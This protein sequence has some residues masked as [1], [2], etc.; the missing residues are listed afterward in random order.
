MSAAPT[1]D[2]NWLPDRSAPLVGRRAESV[3]LNS[4]AVVTAA[5]GAVVAIVGLFSGAPAPVEVE[6]VRGLAVQ[7]YGSGVYRYDTLFTGAGNR[8][9]DLVTL[10]VGVPLMIGCLIAVRKGSARGRLLMPGAFAWFL[11]VYSTMSVGAAYNQLFLAYV[12]LFA[13]SIFGGALAL[14]AVDTATLIAQAHALP[15]RWPGW[16]LVVSGIATPF[17][18]VSPVVAGLVAGAVPDRLDTYSTFVTTA[19]DVAII[20]PAALIA[21]VLVLKGRGLGFVMAV[22]LLVI[23]GAL[24]PVIAAQT[25]FQRGA[26]IDFAPAELVGPI[27]AFMTLSGMAVAA[28]VLIVKAVKS[29]QGSLMAADTV[30]PS[31]RTPLTGRPS[32]TP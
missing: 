1:T 28:L 12:A 29:P 10:A 11:Y 22:P 4:L 6:S 7:L 32:S 13:I 9:T 3:W 23:E 19:L 25:V 2:A 8:G 16:L 27:G 26:G 17:I 24:A 5:V 30:P 31:R 14:R 20:T 18:W 21:G 15:K